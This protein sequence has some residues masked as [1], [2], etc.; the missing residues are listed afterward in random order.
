M[1]EEK[2][3]FNTK[4]IHVGNE[5]DEVTGAVIPSIHTSS[6]FQQEAVGVHKG[7]DYSRAGNPTQSRMEA[8]VASLENGKYGIAFSSGMAAISSLFQ[9]LKKGEH[10]I[11]GRN[12]YGGTYRLVVDVLQK[13]G[14]EFSFVDFR[15]LDKVKV[16]IKSNTSWIFVETPT[17]PLL[18][19]CDIHAVSKLCK[20]NNIRLAVDNTFMSPYG[21]NPLDLGADV[22]MHSATKFIGGHSDLIAGVLIT[23]NDDLADQLYFIQKSV[24]AVLSPFDLWLLL[25]STKTLGLR[26][27]CQ[28]DNAFH[29][30]KRLHDNELTSEV[31]Y[32]GLESHPQYELASSNN[33]ILMEI[34]S[35]AV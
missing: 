26:V 15:D 10:V 4:A 13:H 17:N 32:P 34:Q 14:F 11:L 21:Q 18:E 33:L 24:G 12:V 3:G 22:V 31:I 8:N 28:S 35:M 25:R 7:Y 27:Q 30:A 23:N 19:L 5:P 16:E 9:L 1:E 2:L 6:T 29:I 20:D